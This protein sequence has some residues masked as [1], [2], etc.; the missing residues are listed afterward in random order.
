MMNQPVRARRPRRRLMGVRVAGTG[1]YVPDAV[2]TNDHL[3]HRFGCDPAWIVRQTGI[4][5][6]RHALPHQ[7]T[8]DLCAEAA[9]RCLED[10]GA[11]P[12][13]VDLLLIATSTPD[14]SFPSTACLVQERLGLSCPAVDLEAACAGLIYALVT[15]ATYLV[16]GASETVLVI[17]GDCMSRVLSPTDVKIY[18]LLGD[19]AAA[20]LLTRGQP[21]EGLLSYELGADGSGS[22]LVTRPAGGSRLPP[23]PERLA[24]GLQYMHMDGHAVFTW[25]VRILSD[26]TQ[27]VLEGAGLGVEDIDLFVPHQANVRIINAAFDVLG[28][29]R[30]K[31]YQNLGR[32]GNTAAASVPLAL[33]EARSEGRVERGQRVLLSGYGA[34]LTWGTVVLCW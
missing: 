34:G 31:V 5:E 1:G 9:A 7:A 30:D 25:A 16:A 2:V 27:R 6:R 33:H 28:V 19:A 11:A 10:A 21:D 14:M 32:Y 20:L 29:P 17:G 18:P 24:E 4:H 22:G 12:H 26:S 3:H 8:S 13:D 23:T 15:A